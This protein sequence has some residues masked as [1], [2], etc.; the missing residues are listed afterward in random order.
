MNCLKIL[1]RGIAVLLPLTTAVASAQSITT[2]VAKPERE[3]SWLAK[4]NCPIVIGHRGASGY[5]P[6][7]TLEAYTLAIRQG[8]D[9]IEPDL[10]ITKDGVLIARHEPNLIATTDV[11][12]RAE[13]ASRKRKVKVDGAEEE[14][15][16]AFDFT[17][18]E[19]KTLRAIQS[20]GER[21][22]EFNGKFGIPTFEEVVQLAQ[23]ESTRGRV[24]GIY[25]ETKHPT[26]HQEVGLPLEDRLVNILKR[27]GLNSKKAPVFIQSFETAN[28]KYLATRTPVRL[29]QL[30]DAD[31]VNVV[32]GEI[33]YAAP[34]DRP[35]DWT[36]AGR[37]GTF[38]SLLTPE[39]LAEV[40]KYAYGIGPWKRHLIT[41]KAKLGAD[42]KPIDVNGDGRVNDADFDT[43]LN[44]QL[45]QNIHESGLALHTWTFRNEPRRLARTYSNDPTKE[46]M[47]YFEMGVSGIFTDFPD[48]GVAARDA[49]LV[50]THGKDGAEKCKAGAAN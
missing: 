50:R 11:S 2:D 48:S 8:A 49:F 39:G 28:L 35:Y 22:Q 29:I 33:T 3:K 21:S 14:G 17:L 9:F 47:A 43:I 31:D 30:A 1:V 34:F 20:S 23:A 19:I 7:H 26:L 6:E 15:F 32:T 40:A 27:Y 18:A 36:V 37:S 41:V 24:V 44:L 42:G 38:G 46:M 5:L 25:P 45:A 12:S 13:F 16:F 10:V 4:D